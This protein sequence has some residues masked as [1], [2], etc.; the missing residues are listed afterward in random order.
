MGMCNTS[1]GKLNNSNEID[2]IVGSKKR[3][4]RR[5]QNQADRVCRYQHVGG[6]PSDATLKYSSVTNGIKNAHSPSKTLR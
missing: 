5:D 3:F 2:T 6:H 1:V 4:T